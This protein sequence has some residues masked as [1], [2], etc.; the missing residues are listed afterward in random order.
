MGGEVLDGYGVFLVLKIGR[1]FSQCCLEISFV[2]FVGF[3]KGHGPFD[4]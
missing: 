4:V 2:V 1:A 3:E